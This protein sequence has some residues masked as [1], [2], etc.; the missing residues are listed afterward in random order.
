MLKYTLAL[1]RYGHKILMINRQKSPWQGAW[2]GVGGKLEIDE[3]PKEC[4]IR[5]IWEETGIRLERP[6]FRGIVTWN[7]DREPIQGMYLYVANLQSEDLINLPRETR[8][9]ILALKEISWILAEENYGTVPTLRIFMK[10]AIENLTADPADYHCV[11]DG[12]RLI[13]TEMRRIP[14]YILR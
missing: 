5:E 6:L 12:E 2:N 7:S 10:D 8:E 4:V 3:S 1:L 9:G 14:E 11:F 13:H